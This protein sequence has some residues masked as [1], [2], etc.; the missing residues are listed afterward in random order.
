MG[1]RQAGQPLCRVPPLGHGLPRQPVNQVQ[2]NVIE[3][4]VAGGGEGIH[5]LLRRVASAQH[6]QQPV[7]QALDTK[8]DAVD[9]GGQ[10]PVTQP[11]R[12]V[13]GVG[14]DGYFRS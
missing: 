7:V 11:G 5:G 9:P 12:K 14:L 1:R 10:H 4:G 2:V 13:A 6:L 8:A 3:P